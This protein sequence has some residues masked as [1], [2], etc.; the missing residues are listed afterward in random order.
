MFYRLRGVSFDFMET[1][2]KTEGFKE[3]LARKEAFI[4]DMERERIERIKAARAGKPV[5]ES[6]PLTMSPEEAL[7]MAS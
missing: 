7:A 5:P 6:K 3:F 1:T 4:R 2:G